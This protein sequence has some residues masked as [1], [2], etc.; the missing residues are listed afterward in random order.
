MTKKVRDPGE[1]YEILEAPNYTQF[2]NAL[3]DVVMRRRQPSEWMVLSAICRLTFGW[4][5]EDGDWISYSQMCKMTGRSRRT[6]IEAVKELVRINILEVR[7]PLRSERSDSPNFYRLNVN[8]GE[9]S[10]RGAKNDTENVPFSAPTKERRT[11]STPSS[12]SGK[13]TS[14]PR[15]ADLSAERSSDLA[16]QTTLATLVPSSEGEAQNDVHHFSIFDRPTGGSV[17]IGS[18]RVRAVVSA[19][20][21]RSAASKANRAKFEKAQQKTQKG[22]EQ[23]DKIKEFMDLLASGNAKT[24]LGPR[25][26]QTIL[27]YDGPLED[28]TEPFIAVFTG[29]WKHK[30]LSENLSVSGIANNLAAYDKWKHDG[31]PDDPHKFKFPTS[32]ATRTF[33]K[34]WDE[35]TRARHY[36]DVHNVTI[37]EY[38]QA[39]ADGKYLDEKLSD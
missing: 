11:V 10:S 16:P 32:E 2:P 28:L 33:A 14:T 37:E 26:T 8:R 19:D 18:D 24:K 6:V 5:K 29:K 36:A 1:W 35:E 21:L 34:K 23:R 39:R 7:H 25:D 22:L 31:S 12:N 13:E 17:H 3:L 15:P 30:W 9:K 27:G 4:N 38:W 20:A